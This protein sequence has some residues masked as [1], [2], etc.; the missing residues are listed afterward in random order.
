MRC[1]WQGKAGWQSGWQVGRQI[2]WHTRGL[3]W[4][5][6]GNTHSLAHAGVTRLVD[7]TH[8]DAAG[9]ED[10]EAEVDQHVPE[11]TADPDRPGHTTT[12]NWHG[13]IEQK[14]IRE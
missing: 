12:Q 2:G 14:N 1:F 3:W 5:V 9:E 8:E 11:L 7:A 6:G 13:E 10:V 4:G